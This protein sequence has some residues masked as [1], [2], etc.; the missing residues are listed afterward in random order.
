[1]KSLEY[2]V[3]VGIRQVRPQGDYLQNELRTMAISFVTIIKERA[4]ILTSDLIECLIYCKE[5][6]LL[7]EEINHSINQF[8]NLKEFNYCC[9]FP[10]IRLRVVSFYFNLFLQLLLSYLICWYIFLLEHP[11]IYGITWTLNVESWSSLTG[12]S[13]EF[14][15]YWKFKV[16]L[17]HE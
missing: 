1:M 16:A 10:H 8:R 7:S 4:R 12:W 5:K 14:K 17:A 9:C 6:Y 13:A 2:K 3:S 15:W 11:V